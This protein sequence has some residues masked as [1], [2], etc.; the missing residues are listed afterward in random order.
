M[1]RKR[2]TS[3]SEANRDASSLHVFDLEPHLLENIVALAR[4]K[5]KYTLQAVNKMWYWHVH[6]CKAH[7]QRG[8]AV[9]IALLGSLP[10]WG[11]KYLTESE[12]PLFILTRREADEELRNGATFLTECYLLS[13]LRSGKPVDIA[14]DEQQRRYVQDFVDLLVHFVSPQT[15]TTT[16]VFW[17]REGAL[18]K[19]I[20]S[21]QAHAIERGLPSS[22]VTF[23]VEPPQTWIVD[24]ASEEELHEYLPIANSYHVVDQESLLVFSNLCNEPSMTSSQS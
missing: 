2:S 6:Q 12:R 5:V 8:D 10:P 23:A 21:L 4:D 11:Q 19:D 17:V 1:K 20:T 24:Q 13:I 22:K 18:V 7:R 3:V 15:A 16:L 9:R 14:Y